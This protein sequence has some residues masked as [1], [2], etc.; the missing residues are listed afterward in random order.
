MRNAA[1]PA[2]EEKEHHLSAAETGSTDVKGARTTL[3]MRHDITI[4]PT[5]G[6]ARSPPWFSSEEYDQHAK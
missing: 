1:Y 3:S 4:Q 6:F 2:D 5:L